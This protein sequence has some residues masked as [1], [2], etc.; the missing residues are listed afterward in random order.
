MHHMIDFKYNLSTETD[1][2][3]VHHSAPNSKLRC[4]ITH[5]WITFLGYWAFISYYTCYTSADQ[6]VFI[7]HEVAIYISLRGIKKSLNGCVLRYWEGWISIKF[8]HTDSPHC[9]WRHLPHLV[10]LGDHFPLNISQPSPLVHYSCS[11]SYMCH[12]IFPYLLPQHYWCYS[13]DFELLYLVG[14]SHISHYLQYYLHQMVAEC[15]IN[16]LTQYQGWL[17]WIFY[18][19]LL[20]F[21]HPNL[22]WVHLWN[23]H[24]IILQWATLFILNFPKLLGKFC[25]VKLSVK[26]PNWIH[27]ILD[28]QNCM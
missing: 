28:S 3:F 24:A 4:A 25:K 14:N 12:Y 9:P 5:L 21:S 19:L 7:H 6:D 16:H 20:V 18:H 2:Q 26:I 10:F 15:A 1:L 22:H 8:L 23:K 11:Q 13:P 27:T 17:D